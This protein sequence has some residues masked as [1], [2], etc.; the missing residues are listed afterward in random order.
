[1]LRWLLIKLTH[2]LSTHTTPPPLLEKDIENALEE[3][4]P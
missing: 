2:L 4:M 3:F 1:M